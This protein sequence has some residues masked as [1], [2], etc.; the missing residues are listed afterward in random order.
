MHALWRPPLLYLFCLVLH[1]VVPCTTR[2]GYACDDRGTPLRY[3]INGFRVLL[4]VTAGF[5]WASTHKGHDT[6]AESVDEL[7]WSLGVS[8]AIGLVLSVY[9]VFWRARGRPLDLRLRCLTVGATK[10][11]K[12]SLAA[13]AAVVQSRGPLSNLFFGMEFNPS[14]RI[15]GVPVDV[16]MYLYLAGAVNLEIIV[17]SLLFDVFSAAPIA[18]SVVSGCLTWFCLEYMFFEHV[19]LYTYDLFA[20]R[21]GFKLVWGCFVFYPYFYAIP[22]I[23]VST[24]AASGAADVTPSIAALSLALFAVGWICTRGAN[25]QK[26]Q[27]KVDPKRNRFLGCMDQ[28]AVPGSR[29]RLLCSGFWGLARHLNYLGETLQALG[30]ALPGAAMG[31][32]WAFLYPVYYALLFVGRERDDE[33]IC[34]AKYGEVLWK[35]YTDLVPWRIVPGIY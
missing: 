25:L 11:S 21:I 6:R 8:N 14:H 9:Y 22:M 7:L 26:F 1:V 27:F 32:W 12:K 23:A 3:R 35:K 10:K 34:K 17:L 4:L 28:R 2:T 15:L 13:E 20:E 31:A 16:K 5:L 24:A 29:G 18:A 19:H 30:V 33:W